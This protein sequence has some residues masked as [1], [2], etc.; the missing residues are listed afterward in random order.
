MLALVVDQGPMM[1]VGGDP[2]QAPMLGH[3]QMSSAGGMLYLGHKSTCKGAR[4]GS[5][6]GPEALVRYPLCLMA[7]CHQLATVPARY[8][9]GVLC[10]QRC[11]VRSLQMLSVSDLGLRGAHEGS[12]SGFST[13]DD[14]DAVPVNP[15]RARTARVF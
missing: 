8:P 7:L 2:L 12:A 14:L 5:V 4:G 11:F 6:A 9:L 15:E 13:D 1:S 10:C 3:G